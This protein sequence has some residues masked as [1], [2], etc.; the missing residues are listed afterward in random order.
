[1][2][3][4]QVNSGGATAKSYETTFMENLSNNVSLAVLTVSVLPSY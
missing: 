3:N 1:M 4:S 2:F